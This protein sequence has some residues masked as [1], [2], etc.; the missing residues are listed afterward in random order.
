MFIPWKS[1][2]ERLR[3]FFRL[4]FG[5]NCCSNACFCSGKRNSPPL[6]SARDQSWQW[7]RR[8][9]ELFWGSMLLLICVFHP[10]VLE[11]PHMLSNLRVLLPPNPQTDQGE[12]G[13]SAERWE[14]VER[15][16]LRR[17]SS[18]LKYLFQHLL[19]LSGV[20]AAPRMCPS[21]G[22]I[23]ACCNLAGHTM[24]CQHDCLNLYL[25][26]VISNSEEQAFV[27]PILS[28]RLIWFCFAP[29]KISEGRGFRKAKKAVLAFE[30]VC[31]SNRALIV[32]FP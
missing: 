25:I 14:W 3:C 9:R 7:E 19:I 20:P 30:I 31:A 27:Y 12:R 17:P 2:E 6:C 13:R 28:F 23:Q 32:L 4:C 11:L 10:C 8:A 5:R 15:W 16:C 22:S 18:K 24:H 21:A 1:I 29:L 26:S